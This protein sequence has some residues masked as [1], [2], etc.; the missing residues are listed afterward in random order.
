MIYLKKYIHTVGPKSELTLTILILLLLYLIYNGP[1]RYNFFF[2][3]Q[4][5]AL[6]L[7]KHNKNLFI[8]SV[9]GGFIETRSKISYQK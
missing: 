9:Y 7:K 8:S 6:Q 1:Y 3:S 5:F 4:L 2:D